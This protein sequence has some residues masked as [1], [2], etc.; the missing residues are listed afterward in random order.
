MYRQLAEQAEDVF[1]KQEL[2][3]LAAGSSSKRIEVSPETVRGMAGIWESRKD[4]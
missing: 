4:S 3:E 1:I 2:L